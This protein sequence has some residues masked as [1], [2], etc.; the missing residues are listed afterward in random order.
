MKEKDIITLQSANKASQLT[1]QTD[2]IKRHYKI[3]YDMYK[4]AQ[5]DTMLVWLNI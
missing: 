4:L 1:T 2:Y 5:M 3:K